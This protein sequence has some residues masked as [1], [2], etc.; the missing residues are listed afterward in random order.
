MTTATCSGAFPRM[1]SLLNA[2]ALSGKP[3]S[4]LKRG[5]M[6]V[7]EVLHVYTGADR[8]GQRKVLIFF[9]ELLRK[10]F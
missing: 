2:F 3:K 10:I 1:I 7:K 6:Q 5:I 9:G 4:C 8:S